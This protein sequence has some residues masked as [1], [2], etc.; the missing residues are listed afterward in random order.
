V[1]LVV[2][3]IA[4]GAGVFVFDKLADDDAKARRRVRPRAPAAARQRDGTIGNVDLP[5]PDE[6]LPVPD[7]PAPDEPAR[8]RPDGG[9]R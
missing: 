1:W 7:P 8:T 9:S 2:M 4:L 3:A 5:A 6:P